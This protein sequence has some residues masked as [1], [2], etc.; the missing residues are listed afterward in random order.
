MHAKMRRGFSIQNRC[1]VA[2]KSNP[3]LWRQGE[4]KNVDKQP[5][6]GLDFI[7]FVGLSWPAPPRTE[8]PSRY[9]QPDHLLR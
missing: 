7:L 4:Q 3:V 6:L 2:M 5:I 8:I 9:N 1:Q